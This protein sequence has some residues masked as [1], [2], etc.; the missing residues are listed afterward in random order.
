[1]IQ[2]DDARALAAGSD[3]ATLARLSASENARRLRG[4]VRGVTLDDDQV[5]IHG[6][7]DATVRAG[8]T[9]VVVGAANAWD[10][11]Q[12]VDGAEYRT[13]RSFLVARY[14]GATEQETAFA[15]IRRCLDGATSEWE[16]E[17]VADILMARATGDGRAIIERLGRTSGDDAASTEAAYRA[18][19]NKLDWQL[20]GTDEV[21]ITRQYGPSGSFR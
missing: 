7:L 9:V 12:A 19:L 20:D 2:D 11:L 21:R 17:M 4:L 13:L 6:I 15:N 5:T 14:Y 18:G 8:D 1:M 3:T 10:M 16:E